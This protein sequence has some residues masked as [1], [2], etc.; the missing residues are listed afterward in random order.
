MLKNKRIFFLIFWSSILLLL[1]ILHFFSNR[2]DSDNG[3]FLSGAW[4]LF[5]GQEI[6][7]DFF[8]FTAPGTFYV[9]WMIWQLLGVSYITVLIISILSLFLSV[10]LVF[11]L[12]QL[13]NSQTAYLATSLFVCSTIY[14]PI[15]TSH[16]Y[17]LLFVFAA[18][19]LFIKG[20]LA[21]SQWRILLSAL[22]SG[23]AIIFLQTIGLELTLFLFFWLLFFYFKDRTS[24]MT[25]IWFLPLAAGPLSLLFF[26]WSPA[27][28]FKYLIGFPFFQYTKTLDNNYLIWLVLLG[29][30]IFSWLRTSRRNILVL[31]FLFYIQTGLL[32]TTYSLPDYYHISFIIAPFLIIFSF[33]FLEGWPKASWW[34]LNRSGLLISLTTTIVVFVLLVNFYNIIVPVVYSRGQQPDDFITFLKSNCHSRFIYAGPFLPFI[35]LETRKLSA[36]SFHWLITNHHTAEQFLQA[37]QEIKKNDPDCAVLYYRGVEKYH[38]NQDNVVDNYIK[39]NYQPVASFYG[40][41]VLFK[42]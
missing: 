11:K 7:R 31:N 9:I 17:V 1:V 30:L 38:Y 33:L 22:L 8:A 23:I 25:L 15:I 18:V 37:S 19:Y 32:L 16:N 36:S 10:I 26:K 6:Y 2:F 35:Y 28:L 21:A 40:A 24:K 14:W 12:A 4:S 29:I 3:L 34:P 27:L 20:F 13:L 39:Q 42:K 5:N 41:V